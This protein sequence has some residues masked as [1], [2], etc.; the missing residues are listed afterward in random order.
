V[1][2]D[3]GLYITNVIESLQVYET[4]FNFLSD[5]ASEGTGYRGHEATECHSKVRLA[6]RPTEIIKRSKVKG[7]MTRP[8]VRLRNSRY[9]K[10]RH[11]KTRQDKSDKTTIRRPGGLGRDGQYEMQLLRNKLAL[12]TTGS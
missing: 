9:D 2:I 11:D 1:V 3:S 8:M 6:I 4:T 12:G 10:T 5:S 7:C